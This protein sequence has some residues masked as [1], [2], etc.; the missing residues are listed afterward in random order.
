ML[1]MNS[2]LQFIFFLAMVL[3]T[4]GLLNYYFLRKHR[5]IITGKTFPLALL[6]LILFTVIL[7]PVATFIFSAKEMSMLASITGF[8]GYSWLAF[9]GLFLVI[10]GILDLFVFILEKRGKEFSKK[11]IQIITAVAVSVNVI[12]IFYGFFEA[13]NIQIEKLS[14]SS[15]K[16][17]EGRTI[18]IVQISDVHFSPIISV[19]SAKKI[20]DMVQ[21]QNPDIIISTGDFL[22]RAIRKKKE[23][24]AVMRTLKAPLGKYAITGNH[25][26][27]AGIK[28]S[29]DFI[30]N[31]GF[32]LIRNDTV[33]IEDMLNLT[34]VDDLSASRFGYT[35]K[36]SEET[37]LSKV[38]S[39]NYTIL[40]KHQPKVDEK[41]TQYYDLQLSGHTHAGQIFPFTLFAKIAFPYLCGFYKVND[42]T[43]IYV[44]RGTGTWGP[45]IRFLVSPEITVIELKHQK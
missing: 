10:H 33:V 38:D 23:V 30:K 39:K 7:A 5:F 20:R 27:I 13:Q 42:N 41:N 37:V 45:P 9:L 8:T 35:V 15:P 16:I 1:I 3:T 43:N 17:K 2:T 28:Y 12:I 44:N 29:V 32:K 24:A 40:L 11:T 25:E 34:G 26:F 14:F 21:K 22:D 4:Y 6:R 31:S 19:H 18:K 36:I